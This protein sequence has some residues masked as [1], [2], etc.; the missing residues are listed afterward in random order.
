MICTARALRRVLSLLVT[1]VTLATLGTSTAHGQLRDHPPC[2]ERSPTAGD[3][4]TTAQWPAPLNRQVSFRARGIPLRDA[5]GRLAAVA[6]VR[7]S[8]SAEALPLDRSVCFERATASLGDVL[9]ALIADPSVM[10]REVGV[11]HVALVPAH[12]PT[13]MS[14]PHVQTPQLDRVVVTGSAVGAPRRALTI[15]LGVVDGTRLAHEEPEGTLSQALDGSVAGVWMWEQSPTSVLSRYASVRG[16]SS[17]G[18]SYPKVYVDGIEVANPLVITHFTPEMIERVEVIRGPQGA[19]LYGTDAISG[20]V[21]IV[22][23]NDGVAG[24]GTRTMLRSQVGGAQ[25]NFS[26]T[27]AVAQQHAF[28][29]RTGSSSRSASLGVAFGGVGAY[30]PDARSHQLTASTSGR[31]V[32]SRG[33]LSANARFFADDAGSPI[34]PLLADSAFSGRDAAAIATRFGGR[35]QSVRQYTVGVTGRVMNGELWTHSAVAGIDGYGLNGVD[36]DISPIPQIAD[37]TLREAHSTGSRASL[38]LSSV[39]NRSLTAGT[40]ALTFAAEHSILQEASDEPAVTVSQPGAWMFR[41]PRPDVA[42]SWSSSGILAQAN[43]GFRDFL[44]LTA[45][46][47]LE[48][49]GGFADANSQT[50]FLPMLGAA[51]VRGTPNAMIKFRT[52]YGKGI[53][54]QRTTTRE[55]TWV[56]THGQAA[57]RAGLEPEAQS[58]IEGGIDLYFGRQFALQVTRFD[59]LASGLIQRV[60]LGADTTRR[61]GPRPRAVGYQLQN[62][63]EIT[64]R[65]WEIEASTAHGPLSL[66]STLSLVD[67]RVRTLARGYSGDLRAGDRMLEVPARTASMTARWN[68]RG[69]NASTTV[70]RAADWINYDRL[71]IAWAVVNGLHP[72]PQ[73]IGGWLRGF[74]DTY[75]GVT[76][77]RASVSREIGRGI[78]LLG[79]GDNLLNYQFGEPD[80]VTV[81]PGRTITFGIRAAF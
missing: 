22:T 26:S 50:S 4:D 43:V 30:V 53:R 16:A 9:V 78:T 24:G 68:S 70:V 11:D 49:N 64:N 21:N 47:R 54:P 71:G 59:Q 37:A 31:I 2:R 35:T 73:Y 10:P 34:S 42:A 56:G 79:S 12:A 52:A 15:A 1:L 3:A 44:Y 36:D 66:E 72:A 25:S 55:A 8:Y 29:L 41:G 69:W 46:T 38:R 5:L 60:T 28:A 45:G 58:G 39:M 23:R 40:L 67:S 51:F 74:W 27:P 13:L 20:V 77:V 62:V 80:N 14:L 7:L 57:S 65:G 33:I 48:R 61:G 75:D 76:R 6:H 18:S 19:A 63:G 17:F 32:A 81:L